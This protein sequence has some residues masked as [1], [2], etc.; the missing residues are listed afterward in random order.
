MLTPKKS[1]IERMPDELE[2]WESLHLEVYETGNHN[3]SSP[4]VEE[5]FITGKLQS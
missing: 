5:A 2:V 3:G 1:L 4:E